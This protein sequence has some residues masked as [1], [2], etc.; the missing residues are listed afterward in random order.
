MSLTL[1]F[2]PLASFCQKVLIGLYEVD[3]PFHENV[4]DLSD[5]R[6]R[7]ALLELWPLGKFPVLSDHARGQTVAE[8]TIILEYLDQHYGPERLVP[9]DPGRALACRFADRFY[10]TYIHVPMQKVV[11]D[12]FRP[13]GQHDLL[14]V[15]EA[16]AQLATAYAY[17]DAELC[18]QRW[19]AGADFSL[20]DCA[21]AP[22]LFYAQKVRP[23]DTAH[24]RLAAYYQRLCERPSFARVRWPPGARTDP[25][26][27]A[28]ASCAG[29]SISKAG[30]VSS[31]S[32]LSF[33]LD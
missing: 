27:R 20:A 17:A 25:D 3:A 23:I 31:V 22:A 10:D 16:R 14:G 9:R 28:R 15:E 4:V 11:V 1:H 18:S 8:S 2:H 26:E 19:A 13:D 29:R 6:Q 12:T 5:A 24:A 21:A 7:A 30:C 33:P 32:A